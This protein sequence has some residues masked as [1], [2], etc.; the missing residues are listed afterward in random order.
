VGGPGDHAVWSVGPA[1]TLNLNRYFA[2][3]GA[4]TYSSQ[5]DIPAKTFAFAGGDVTQAVVGLKASVHGQHFSFFAKARSGYIRFAQG[6]V[7]R[8]GEE[9]L[10]P[11]PGVTIFP[12]Y[13]ARNSPILDLGGGVEYAIS[14]KL[15]VRTEMGDT[16][17]FWRQ[18]PLAVISSNSFTQNLQI[19]SGLYYRFG[20]TLSIEAPRN[21]NPHKFFDKT[22]LALFSASLLAQTA[23]AITTQR[24]MAN[25]R[26]MNVGRCEQ[27]EADPLAR[28]FVKHG[29]GGQI[30]LGAIVNATQLGVTY[31]IHKMGHHKVERFVTVPLTVGSSK[32]A[33]DNLQGGFPDCRSGV[34]VTPTRD[35]KSNPDTN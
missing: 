30:A 31:A 8:I 28:P 23:D 24:F 27:Q 9:P 32:A 1:F 4:Y 33:Y 25:C 21:E 19:S 2:V 22:N 18:E 7:A 16:M 3:D 6:K 35:T 12:Y 17:I 5:K 11:G 20:K 14:R 10:Q 13:E 34:C 26:R 29:W 15:A